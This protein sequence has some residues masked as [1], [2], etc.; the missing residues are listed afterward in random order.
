MSEENDRRRREANRAWLLQLTP[1]QY[2]E[3]V[4]RGQEELD[5][6][7]QVVEASPQVLA[8]ARQLAADVG[9]SKDGVRQALQQAIDRRG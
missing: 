7:G 6:A 1:E 4:A 2:A 8:A 9:V 3:V 5:N